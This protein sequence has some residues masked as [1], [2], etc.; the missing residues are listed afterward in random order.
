METPEEVM[1]EMQ[2]R[3]DCRF[4]QDSSTSVNIVNGSFEEK[5][6]RKWWK[7][8]PAERRQLIH[9]DVQSKH[10]QL[11]PEGYHNGAR[12]GAG[13]GMDRGGRDWDGLDSG[14]V[15]SIAD[16]LDLDSFLRDFFGIPEG[17]AVP[18]PSIPGM[19]LPH[20]FAGGSRGGGRWDVP[21]HAGSVEEEEGEEDS[22]GDFNKFIEEQVQRAMEEGLRQQ[23]QQQRQY[24]QERGA[25]QWQRGGLETE[26]AVPV[27]GG[28]GIGLPPPPSRQA[29]PPFSERQGSKAM[30]I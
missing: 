7:Q 11:G 25:H 17:R 22:W 3:P 16:S 18:M 19:L 20:P 15:G 24:Q 30:S 12:A 13:G 9:R 6:E 27:A 2:A 26:G 29:V 14:A 21:G 23:Q 8:C 1:R 10:G 28:G 4:S 5:V